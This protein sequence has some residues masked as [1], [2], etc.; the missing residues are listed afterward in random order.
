MTKS[1][2]RA[3]DASKPKSD[4]IQRKNV[5]RTSEAP[6]ADSGPFVKMDISPEDF[7]KAWSRKRREALIEILI[8]SLDTLDP[9]PDAEPDLGWRGPTGFLGES[10]DQSAPD[11]CLNAD[12][13]RGLEDEHDGGEPDIEELSLGWPEVTTQDRDGWH[14]GC[15][16]DAELDQADL[17][18]ELGW[19]NETGRN[20][21]GSTF[22][23]AEAGS[24]EWP[25]EHPTW[26][27][28]TRRRVAPP[29]P[30][31]SI[32]DCVRVYR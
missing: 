13:G 25:A 4:T 23:D 31:I 5:K 15:D 8:A 2:Q 26:Q 29:V 32:R 17:E 24:P 12:A 27:P 10:T 22:L 18:P 7:F 1:P 21:V 6:R 16:G 19:C 3:R 28:P 30:T 14:G 9:D 11:F 20:H